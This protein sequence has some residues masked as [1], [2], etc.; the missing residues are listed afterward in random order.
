MHQKTQAA[1]PEFAECDSFVTNCRAIPTSDQHREEHN[2]EAEMEVINQMTYSDLA[3]EKIAFGKAKLGQ[4]FTEAIE[5]L[6]TSQKPSHAK[7]IRFVQLYVEKLAKRSPLPKGEARPTL[8]VITAE[9]TPIENLSE[10][11]DESQDDTP[12]RHER[13]AEPYP[14]D[15]GHD[16]AGSSTLEPAPRCLDPKSGSIRNADS[17]KVLC[18]QQQSMIFQDSRLP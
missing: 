9:E 15:R 12:C 6:N 17:V 11:E 4:P 1:Y 5:Q 14:P 8:D 13:H 7:F 16:A 3:K 10:S 2:Q 18:P